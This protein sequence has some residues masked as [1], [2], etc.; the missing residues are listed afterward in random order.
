[1]LARRKIFIQYLKEDRSKNANFEKGN[2]DAWD[3]LV[4]S[5]TG[6]QFDMILEA[7]ENAH[8]VWKILLNKYEVSDEKSESLMDVAME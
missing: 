7:K 4:L 6:V 1:M 8:T 3:Q 5:L 2:T